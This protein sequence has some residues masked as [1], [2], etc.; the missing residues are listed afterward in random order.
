[1]LNI[2][3]EEDF[4]EILELF[5]IS[6]KEFY[7]IEDSMLESTTFDFY[8]YYL[9]Q[10]EKKIESDN[11]SIDSDIQDIIK[12]YWYDNVTYKINLYY[13]LLDLMEEKLSTYIKQLNLEIRINKFLYS[14]EKIEIDLDGDFDD[15]LRKGMDAEGMFDFDSHSESDKQSLRK[16]YYIIREILN[17]YEACEGVTNLHDDIDINDSY[18]CLDSDDLY[19]Y[20]VKQFNDG[21]VNPGVVLNYEQFEKINK[22]LDTNLEELKTIGIEIPEKYTNK[23]NSIFIEVVK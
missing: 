11:L 14:D 19:D 21:Y 13:Y 8:E 1:M 3:T 22:N 17:Y 6:K 15:V 4:F 7:R 5:N 2:S 18:N 16:P 23:T 12:D 9:P 20:F 10:L